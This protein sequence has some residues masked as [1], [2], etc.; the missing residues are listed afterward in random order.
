[1]FLTLA[2]LMAALLALAA[3]TPAQA[4]ANTVNFRESFIFPV[5]NA[6]E[7]EFVLLEG[8]FHGQTKFR[9]NKK[10]GAITLEFKGNAHGTGVGLDSG[11]EYVFNGTFRSSATFGPGGA[12]QASFLDRTRLISKGSEEN[13]F[14]VF[15]GVL[16]ID[17]N[18]Q[19][20]LDEISFDIECRG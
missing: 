2:V 9:V 14:L 20:I 1:L 15:R 7:D 13:E 6:C 12:F 16:V 19:L 3:P 8:E 11:I 10:T 18:F 4:Q 17:E 5:Y